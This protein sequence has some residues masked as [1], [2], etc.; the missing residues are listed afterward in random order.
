M[1][2]RNLAY[3]GMIRMRSERLGRDNRFGI[4]HS[5]CITTSD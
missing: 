4:F 3:E 1:M 2:N 5:L